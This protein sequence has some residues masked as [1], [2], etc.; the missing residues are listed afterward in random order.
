MHE[1]IGAAL[2]SM[3][4]E[5]LDDQLAELAYHYSRSDNGGKAVEFCL[6]ACQQC[7]ERGSYAEA[8]VHY[9]SGLAALQKLPDDDRRGELELDLRIA[10]LGALASIKNYGST[11]VEQSAVRAIELGQ[12]AGVDWEKSWWP[13]GALQSMSIARPDTRKACELATELVARAEQHGDPEHIAQ[14]VF[15]LAFANMQMGA[16]R[17][18]AEGFDRGAAIY[19]S[20]PK[21]PTSFRRNGLRHH[22]LYNDQAQICATSSINL[23]LLG[24]PDRALERINA[25]ISLARE[26]PSK[27]SQMMVH[28]FACHVYQHRRDLNA[29]RD[30]VKSALALA[31]ELGDV[32]QRSWSEIYLGWLDAMSGDLGPGIARIRHHLSALR[33]AGTE[34]MTGHFLVMIAEALGQQKQFDEGLRTIEPVFSFVERTNDRLYEAELH[35]F[36]GELLIMWDASNAAQAEQCF[37][38]GIAVSRRQ[39]ARLWELRASTSLARLLRDTNRRDEART[40]LDAIYTWFTEGFDTA[41]LKDAKVL[42]DELNN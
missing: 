17:L 16:F 18:A 14:A 34:V 20:M 37:R 23:S 13:L 1:R 9:E 24:C 26:S 40:M 39:H 33:T 38:T 15:A 21:S 32:F 10:S 8:L 30:H 6:R 41:D 36:K 4:A 3:Y 31:N 5:N 35:R 7:D 28:S 2:E 11:E 42:L 22:T 27:D 19:E 12:R 29:L 25:A